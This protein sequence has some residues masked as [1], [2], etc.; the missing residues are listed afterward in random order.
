M[1]S[2]NSETQRSW[3]LQK[4]PD[5]GQNMLTRHEPQA[6]LQGAGRAII[7]CCVGLLSSQVT[8]DGYHSRPSPGL[9]QESIYIKTF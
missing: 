3:I 7:S 9:N 6:H 1:E 4:E 5:R 8:A 2:Q